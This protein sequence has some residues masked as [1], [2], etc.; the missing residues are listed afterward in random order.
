MR[1]KPIRNKNKI[2]VALVALF[3]MLMCT[4]VG[5][6]AWI[7]TG[8]S[9]A[10]ANGTIDAD[11][12]EGGGGSHTPQNLD[13]VTIT[14]LNP[15]QYYSGYGFVNDGMF[16]DDILLSGTCNFNATNGKSCFTSFRNNKSFKLDVK[17]TTALSGGFS[18]Q[19]ITSSEITLTSSNFTTATLDPTDSTDISTTFALTCSDNNSNFTF[20]FSIKLTYGGALTSFPDLATANIK[21]EFTPKENA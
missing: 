13:V 2:L 8:G 21:V 10:T 12:V 16:D 9:N 6:A 7:T 14:Q 3:T 20:D 15:Y 19:S 1:G 17:L 5:F 4:S 18:G 11:T